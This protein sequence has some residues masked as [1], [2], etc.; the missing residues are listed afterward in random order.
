MTRRIF[1]GAGK[2]ERIRIAG[3]ILTVDTQDD[4]EVKRF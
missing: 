1:G 3:D 2:V 4:S